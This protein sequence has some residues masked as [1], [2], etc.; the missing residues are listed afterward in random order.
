MDAFVKQLVAA[1]F[2]GLGIFVWNLAALTGM[3]GSIAAYERFIQERGMEKIV[4]I[5][6]S[7]PQAVPLASPHLRE[8]HDRIFGALERFAGACEGL[9][10]ENLVV[11]PT[12]AHYAMEPIT[13]D[14]IKILADLWN[15][16]GRM[17]KA[18]GMKLGCHHEFWGG[19]RTW[20][21]IDLFYEH[22]DPEYVYLYI[23]TAQHQIAGVDPVELYV[24]YHERVSGFHLKD[25][26]H[27][28]IVGDYR[29][30]PDAE[31]VAKTT[32]QWFHEMGTP[33]GLVDFPALMHALK[34]FGYTGWVG[35]EHDKVDIG[36]GSYPE[37][38]AVAMW[39]ARNVL[40]PIY[41]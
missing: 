37:S 8:T 21:Q 3:F 30:R 5:F 26:W 4:D 13:P 29:S 39:Y 11:M 2:D 18:H 15:R 24:K 14:T 23:D 17:A 19:L 33:Q 27:V 7:A 1:D 16:V 22:A 6:W 25:T 20:Q 35:V 34:A 31:L 10:V 36:G 38:T 28:D 12:N 40:S 9:A 32:G 41:S